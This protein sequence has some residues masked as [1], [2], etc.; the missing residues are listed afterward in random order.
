LSWIRRFFE[1]L[2]YVPGYY[3]VFFLYI[4]II[5]MV[6]IYVVFF[7]QK[8]TLFVAAAVTVVYSGLGVPIVVQSVVGKLSRSVGWWISTAL[9]LVGFFILL[10]FLVGYELLDGNMFDGRQLNFSGLIYWANIFGI[11]WTAMIA[12]AGVLN[13]AIHHGFSGIR[14][15]VKRDI[16]EIQVSRR[17][18][19]GEP[20][21]FDR[22]TVVIVLMGLAFTGGILILR[23]AL[24][25]RPDLVTEYTVPGEIFA[26]APR[27]LTLM[28]MNNAREPLD[29][30]WV[31]IT[32]YYRYPVQNLTGQ[33]LGKDLLATA[34][35]MKLVED[36]YERSKGAPSDSIIVEQTRE[37]TSNIKE[38]FLDFTDAYSYLGLYNNGTVHVQLPSK[39][40]VQWHTREKRLEA[41]WVGTPGLPFM[42]VLNATRIDGRGTNVS[43]SPYDEV[44]VNGRIRIEDVP[45]GAAYGFN[46]TGIYHPWLGGEF[47]DVESFFVSGR[48][49]VGDKDP[50]R[51]VSTEVKLADQG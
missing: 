9:V 18:T 50:R 41:V 49:A 16:Q 45:P 22:R 1:T 11:I 15:N 8:P 39:F 5:L 33:D 29:T 12:G 37:A 14:E 19:R 34:R 48:V 27:T 25:I 26:D 36:A 47:M 32:G 38:I 20:L 4:S 23:G 42:R 31:E 46:L 10:R 35:R 43:T 28:F 21:V 6:F 24:V 40:I 2:Q 17:L 3:R 30:L 13:M 7:N 51:L 44:F